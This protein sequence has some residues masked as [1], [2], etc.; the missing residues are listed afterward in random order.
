MKGTIVNC[1][2][3]LVVE[4]F[5]KDKWEKSLEDAGISKNTM[6]LP[7]AEV[8]DPTI[9][10]VI[11]AVCKNLGI[12][13]EQVA[14]AFGDYWVNVYSQRVYPH[15]YVGHKTAKDLLL[16]MDSVHVI[17]TK[18]MENARPPRFSYEWEDDK[19]LI[20][21]YRSDRGLI[22]FLVGLTKGVG[23]FYKED[24]SVSKIGTDRIRI[25]FP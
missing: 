4:K 7:F 15:F 19:T 1:L 13:F 5:G 11:Q 21:H 22:D 9:M 17:V 12:T 14:D 18:T 6:F 16:A 24:I 25:V 3:E 8:D 20:M 10:K 2:Q 23:K